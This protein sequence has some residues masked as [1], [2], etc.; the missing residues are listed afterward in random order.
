MT[1]AQQAFFT[2]TSV[3][4]NLARDLET[5]TE[6]LFGWRAST[7]GHRENMLNPNWVAVG[8]AR[9]EGAQWSWATTYGNVT[10]CPEGT[11]FVPPGG[12]RRT[13]LFAERRPASAFDGRLLHHRRC[14][15]GR[16]ARA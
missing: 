11:T 16:C 5:G 14:H 6:V 1:R 7:E 3:G 2:G 12:R 13:D 15:A 4:E 10:D 8:I 9:E